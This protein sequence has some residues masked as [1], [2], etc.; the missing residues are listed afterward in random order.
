MKSV[1]KKAIIFFFADFWYVNLSID[2]WTRSSTRDPLPHI[3][4]TSIIESVVAAV[5]V[6]SSGV[7]VVV[8]SDMTLVIV[9][10]PVQFWVEV[11][12]MFSSQWSSKTVL[13]SEAV[14]KMIF[15]L[16]VCEK[17]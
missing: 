10:S 17:M 4:S 7:D 12:K 15:V 2:T 16:T 14:K 6:V 5:V 9:D 3:T 11:M 13:K 8:G 1:Q